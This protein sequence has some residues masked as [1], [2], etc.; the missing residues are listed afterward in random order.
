MGAGSENSWRRSSGHLAVFVIV[1]LVTATVAVA[2]VVATPGVAGATNAWSAPKSIDSTGQ[3]VSVS[4][5]SATFCAAVDTH[6]LVSG[7]EGR[8][9]TFNG[10]TWSAPATV[11]S[12]VGLSSVSCPSASFCVAVDGNG[13]FLTY[14]GSS[15]TA[16]TSI[17]SARLM[18]VSCT[19][20]TFCVAIDGNSAL[21]YDG[22]SWSGPT[23]IDGST[24]NGDNDIL[25][26]VS[27]ESPTFCI[28]AAGDFVSGVGRVLAYDGTSW[29]GPDTVDSHR[30]NSVSCPTSSYCAAVDISG[31]VVTFNGS[32]W[33]TPGN[34]DEPTSLTSVSCAGSLCAA[35]N[36]TGDAYVSDAGPITGADI[37]GSAAFLTVSC[38]T[39]PFCAAVDD[40]GNVLTYGPVPAPIITSFS[41]TSG[42]VGTVVTIKGTGLA[43]ATKVTFDGVKGTITKNTATKLKV[44]VPPGATS[45]KIKVTTLGGAAK[46]AAPFTVT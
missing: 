7:S 13:D 39:G 21:S 40:L 38:A 4:C 11:D 17:D 33:D 27:C 34:V 37:D 31:D 3:V 46:T 35:V 23:Q 1:S 9:L 42:S 18:S 32:T 22:T 6:A 12:S 25:K 44:K 41:P 30:L 26:Q 19:S 14:S 16:P 20:S 8:A 29:T 5:P 36:L 28:A 10:S 24:F 45:A 43:G 2:T 15:W